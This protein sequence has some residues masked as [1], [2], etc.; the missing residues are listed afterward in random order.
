MEKIDPASDC[1]S[2]RH[3]LLESLLM[4]ECNVI[5]EFFS[6]LNDVPEG[7]TWPFCAVLC[8]RILV[9]DSRDR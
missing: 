1:L 8:Q 4:K 3:T 2:N 6:I 9:D 5:Q 7:V